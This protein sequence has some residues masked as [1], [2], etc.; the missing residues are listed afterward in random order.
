MVDLMSYPGGKGRAFPQLINL[1]PP[2]GIYIETHMGS[3]AVLRHKRPAARTIGIERD[4]DVV[5]AWYAETDA[6]PNA[7]IFTGNAAEFLRGFPFRGDE[8]VYADPP[9][10]PRLRRQPRRYR[11]DYACDD[12]ESLLSILTKLPCMVMIS[13]YACALYDRSLKD[14]HRHDLMVAGQTGLRMESLWMNY[15]PPTVLHDHRFLGATFREREAI[16]RRRLTLMNKIDR[17]PVLERA[18]ILA[19]IV[20]CYGSELDALS[21]HVRNA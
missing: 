14:W 18:A 20:A 16:S 19:E 13:G 1:M 17:A 6:V 4:P 8:L 10:C 2:H 12:H 11:V 9:Y 5:A 7:E 15:P 21:D 3:G